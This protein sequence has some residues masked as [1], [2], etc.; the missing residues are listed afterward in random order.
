MTEKKLTIA[1]QEKAVLVA[2]IQQ[3]TK[4]MPD[5]WQTWGYQ[6]TVEYRRCAEVALAVSKRTRHSREELRC[7]LK[8]M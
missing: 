2:E 5:I 1:Q 8:T 3:L 7:A 6:R 4:R